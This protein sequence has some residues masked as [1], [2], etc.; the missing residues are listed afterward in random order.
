M[1]PSPVA[2]HASLSGAG[3]FFRLFITFF[4]VLLNGF[5]VAAEFSLVKVRK[6]KIE[7]MARQ[8]KLSAQRSQKML[9]HLD[10]YLSSC[11]LG[12]TLASL[13][14]GWLAEPAIAQI[15]I[16]GIKALGFAVPASSIIHVIAIIIALA[17]ITVLHITL[18]EQAPKMFAIRRAEKVALIIAY[19]LYL[20]TAI[21]R[22]FIWFINSASNAILRV[23]G[24]SKQVDSDAIH[25]REELM[26]VLTSSAKSGLISGRQRE[27]AENVLKMMELQVRHIMVP[28][29]DVVFLSLK[30][31][32]EENLEKMRKSAHSR[33]PVVKSGLDNVVG[34]LHTKDVFAKLSQ[35]QDVNLEDIIRKPCFVPDTQSL[36]RF[37]FDMRIKYCHMA[38]T[39]DEHGN[40]IGLAFLE[41][42][43]E[44]IVGPIQDE[45]DS[46]QPPVKELPDG[47]FE[48]DGDLPAPEAQE[49][50]GLE[51]IED[52]DTIGGLVI[53]K[54]G[55]M[56][57]TGDKITVE[58][59]HVT[60]VSVVKRR[61][62]R[63]KFER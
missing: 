20:F 26:A 48:I 41:D 11:Q 5:F 22:P 29:L 46:E 10:L 51:D 4:F 24:M 37:I 34:V 56:P 57:K 1:D 7:T 55:R 14:L 16:A 49:I 50:L 62:R 6:I 36:S 9:N 44:E 54:L 23:F 21:F 33:F 18:G 2:S 43:I 28:R 63:L 42:A 52:H 38:V 60:V 12:I 27:Y 39:V 19:P 30:D 47:S 45:F 3:I 53:E 40:I 59:F 17:I 61:I 31:S 32:L 58:S 8:G 25:T 13:I 35:G 15:L